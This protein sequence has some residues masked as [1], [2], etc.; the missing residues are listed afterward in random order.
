MHS[1]KKNTSP[2]S[3]EELERRKLFPEFLTTLFT[4]EIIMEGNWVVQFEQF[5]AVQL[6][7]SL[8]HR[9]PALHPSPEPLNLGLRRSKIQAASLD[10]Q[11]ELL[12]QRD[13][14]LAAGCI[15]SLLQSQHPP[16]LLPHQTLYSR[17][18]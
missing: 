9:N 16:T 13:I 15:V 8:L 14:L 18:H 11:V 4:E 3:P 10:P 2:V 6:N 5:E 17:D 7:V 1:N 12:N